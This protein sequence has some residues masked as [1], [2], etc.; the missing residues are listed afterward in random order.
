M[1][2]IGGLQDVFYLKCMLKKIEFLKKIF[3]LELEKG[4]E[5]YIPE[6]LTCD[7]FPISYRYYD[8]IIL[9]SN[10]YFRKDSKIYH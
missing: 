3:T 10:E 5:V 1:M 6:E 7:R 4:T 2:A 8:P 9:I